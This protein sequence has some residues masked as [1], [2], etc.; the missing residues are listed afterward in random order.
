MSS[1][2]DEPV[3]DKGG[4]GHSVFANAILKS[5]TDMKEEQFTAG[6]IFQKL[7]KPAV[8]ISAAQAPQYRVIDNSGHEFGDFVFSRGTVI[9]DPVPP[10]PPIDPS[11]RSSLPEIT[12]TKELIVGGVGPKIKEGDFVPCKLLDQ[13]LRWLKEYPLPQLRGG[14]ITKWTARV[15]VTVDE[16]GRVIDVKPRGSPSPQGMDSAIKAEAQSWQTNPP[17]YQGKPVKSSFALDI[18]LGQ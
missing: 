4:S 8:T 12:C 10:P 7:I 15:M 3:T 18:N 9:P 11:V 2:G 5:L 17:T 13:S 16:D 14:P 6:D 1:G